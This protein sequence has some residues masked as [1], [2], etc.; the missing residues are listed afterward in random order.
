MLSSERSKS[1]D[2][3]GC[4][5]EKMLSLD[6]LVLVRSLFG[7]H[8]TP[9]LQKYTHELLTYLKFLTYSVFSAFSF[10]CPAVWFYP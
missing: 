10:T 4:W 8:L 5:A 6:G 2:V 9:F 3:P 1:L 7:C